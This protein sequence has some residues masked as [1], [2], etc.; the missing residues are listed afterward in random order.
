[1]LVDHG[2]DERER[3]LP[4]T[5][6]DE[7]SSPA[8]RARHP[9]RRRTPRGAGRRPP[10]PGSSPRSTC[11]RTSARTRRTGVGATEPLLELVAHQ[12]PRRS[13]AAGGRASR[14]ARRRR[15]GR[16]GRAPRC[17]TSSTPV[18]GEAR[19]GDDRR[20]PRR[21]RA[22]SAA[23]RRAHGRPTRASVSPVAV[24]LVHR[25]HV[26][27]L[28]DAALDA[29]ELVAGAGQGEEQEGVDHAGHRRLGLADADRLDQHHVV[30]RGL[31]HEHRLAGGPGHAA[32]RAR[33]W[34]WPGCR[35]RGVG[36]RASASGSCRRAPTRRCAGC[37]GRPRARRPG[38]RPR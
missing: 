31:E 11:S 28:E 33:R 8:G 32:Q 10:P 6:P 30:R 25:D 5:C 4:W 27:E 2:L 26:G 37:S 19:A 15:G 18:A 7:V 20:G 35:R 38:D 22:P 36:R 3:S 17:Q 12:R 16:G 14:R 24:G 23:R 1:M 13:R 9:P 34:G 29:L 21:G